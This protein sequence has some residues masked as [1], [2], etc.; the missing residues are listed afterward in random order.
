[1]NL[2]ITAIFGV[3]LI[4]LVAGTGSA[5]TSIDRT[6][7]STDGF[8]IDEC[9]TIVQSGRYILDSDLTAEDRD[10][11][12]IVEDADDVI[13]DAQNHTIRGELRAAVFVIRSRNVTVRNIVSNDT[14]RAGIRVE[15]SENILL[16][17]NTVKNTQRALFL[18]HSENLHVRENLIQ[19]VGLRDE[20]DIDSGISFRH[21]QNITVEYNQIFGTASAVSITNSSAILARG[22]LLEKNVYGIQMRKFSHDIVV[23]GNVI[24]NHSLC[25][26]DVKNSSDILIDDNYMEQYGGLG[27]EFNASYVTISNNVL[28]DSSEYGIAVAT[29]SRHVTI[30]NNTVVNSSRYAGIRVYGSVSD[31]MITRNTITNNTPTGLLVKEDAFRI[32]IRNNSIISNDGNGIV[33]RP[34]VSDVQITGNRILDNSEKAIDS[35][36]S[37]GVVIENNIQSG[38]IE[39]K[40]GGQESEDTSIS[41]DADSKPNSS[42]IETPGQTGFG[43][44]IASLGL[45]LFAFLTARFR[46]RQ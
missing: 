14:T 10:F 24:R 8:V 37:D 41:E 15:K 42:P 1:M 5:T 45:A 13:L 11:C 9:T 3:I 46:L 19:G 30:T 28:K 36:V 22:N 21:S 23:R 33:I 2:R 34:R 38:D 16:E 17:G 6:D 31:V 25:P 32:T 4:L 43:V 18:R 29:G 27:L 35:G 20:S 26:M 40:G 7:E 44:L 39:D 12:I